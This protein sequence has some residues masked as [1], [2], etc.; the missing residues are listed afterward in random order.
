MAMNPMADVGR[1]VW[2][3]CSYCSNENG[4]YLLEADANLVHV[5]CGACHST[6]WLDTG[7]GAG[8]RRKKVDDLP[9]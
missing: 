1:R 9:E 3:P 5:Q 8:K 2:R 7:H 6:W 4:L